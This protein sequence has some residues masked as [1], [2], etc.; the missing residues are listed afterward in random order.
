MDFYR[1][2]TQEKP[3]GVAC[4]QTI[5]SAKLYISLDEKLVYFETG[6]D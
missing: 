5:K 1:Y 2:R 3:A 4:C 6:V